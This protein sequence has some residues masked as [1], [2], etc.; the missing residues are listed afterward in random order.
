[1]DVLIALVVAAITGI[2]FGLLFR[3]NRDNAILVFFSFGA[4]AFVLSLIFSPLSGVIIFLISLFVFVLMLHMKETRNNEDWWIA[5]VMGVIVY[6]IMFVVFAGASFAYTPNYVIKTE[7][8]K[9]FELMGVKESTRFTGQLH[10]Q[11]FFLT[12][13]IEEA[14]SYDYRYRDGDGSRL[15]RISKFSPRV[16]EADNLTTTGFAHCYQDYRVYDNSNVIDVVWRLIFGPI[17]K[18]A[19]GKERMDMYVPNGT[20]DRTMQV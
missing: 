15:G 6:V 18:V 8:T 17:D 10:G 19:E 16:V 2:V 9:S 13:S 1:M 4:I 7:M 11:L 14:D 3:Q 20:V 5:I 12:A